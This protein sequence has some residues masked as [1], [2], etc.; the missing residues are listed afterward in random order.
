MNT[1]LDIDQVRRTAPISTSVQEVQNL[2]QEAELI[3]HW[4][5]HAGLELAFEALELSEALA[6]KAGIAAALSICARCHTILG[7]SSRALAEAE[8]ALKLF[9]NEN[10]TEQL[11]ECQCVLAGVYSLTGDFFQALHILEETAQSKDVITPKVL[12]HVK[13]VQGSIHQALADY[14]TALTLFHE[15]LLVC[16]DHADIK[17]KA[18]ALGAIGAVYLDL[19]EFAT[20]ISFYQQSLTIYQEVADSGGE[21]WALERM[22]ILCTRMGGLE[23]ALAFHHRSLVL[24]RE[25]KNHRGVAGSMFYIAEIL[26]KQNLEDQAIVMFKESLKFWESAHDFVGMAETYLVFAELHLKEE[27]SHFN[28]MSA[29][30]LLVKC[31]RIAQELGMKRLEMRVHETFTKA[32]KRIKLY[33]KALQHKEKAAELREVISG[34]DVSKQIQQLEITLKK[35]RY[36]R[37]LD[38]SRM[39]SNELI[40][41]R[42]ELES[43]HSHL[44]NISQE[45]H[46]LFSVVYHDLKNPI[47]GILVQ[48][49]TLERY[50]ERMS[51]GDIRNSISMISK[52]AHRMKE[53]VSQLL[54]VNS[55]K[56]EAV[57]I[58]PT[59]VNLTNAVRDAAD[60]LSA[61]AF[62]KSQ[63]IH[64]TGAEH[65]LFVNGD[66]VALQ[67]CVENFLSN[68]IK[69]SS[70]NTSITICVDNSVHKGFV[71][72]TVSDEGKG[73]PPEQLRKLFRG[74]VDFGSKTT[75]GED[76]SGIGLMSVKRLVEQM[77]GAVGCTSEVGV[78]SS[79]FFD[80]PK[81]TL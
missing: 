71:R 1:E 13:F 10:A 59:R 15:S 55:A 53:I 38:H 33:A 54:H 77:K 3:Y 78:G 19:G 79:F 51:M 57:V 2:L 47:A 11:L 7:D 72:C 52:T 46:D 80:I 32:Y 16:A 21:A 8:T 14:A 81:N 34:E 44:Q 20:S 29:T 75:G 12:S 76:S 62:A 73:I 5:V 48:T 49:S 45:K 56:P 25:A 30:E 37:E 18:A 63:T 61:R 41:V 66:R 28:P 50:L 42:K 68:A 9:E 17:G 69:Y 35:E 39:E 43:L 22:G 24:R 31:L 67:R 26:N 40:A 23:D 27:S 70:N 36:E 64:I 60:D 4:N 74:T 65:D 58:D 6:D